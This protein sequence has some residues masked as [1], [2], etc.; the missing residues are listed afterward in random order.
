[1][2][3]MTSEVVTYSIMLQ[4]SVSQRMGQVLGVVHEMIFKGS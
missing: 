1:M 3:S 4:S 2:P